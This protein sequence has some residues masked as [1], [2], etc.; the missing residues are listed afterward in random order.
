MEN[1]KRNTKRYIDLF[2]ES[3]DELLGPAP[4]EV[5]AGSSDRL[6]TLTAVRMRRHTEALAKAAADG[7][8][9]DP[10]MTLP[11]QLM[12]RYEVRFLPE[13][14]SE[15]VPLRQ[16]SAEH[17]GALVCIKAMVTRASDVKP[18]VSVE[19]LAAV[20]AILV[21]TTP[22]LPSPLSGGGGYLRV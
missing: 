6:D 20:A 16:V 15:F 12:R 4:S 5:R 1:I 22:S 18:M 14:K 7:Q 11:P 9:V 8:L 21:L 19:G 3:I 10:K 13:V 2:S 17:I